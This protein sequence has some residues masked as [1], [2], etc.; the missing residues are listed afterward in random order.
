LRDL[1]GRIKEHRLKGENKSKEKKLRYGASFFT[2]KN[3][4]KHI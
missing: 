2:H 1:I 3:N 4:L